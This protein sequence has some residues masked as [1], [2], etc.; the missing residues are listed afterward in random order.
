MMNAGN[1]NKWLKVTLKGTQSNKNG[2]GA[3]VEIYGV[4]GKQIRDVQSGTGFG[5]M[6]T[7]NVHFGIGQA[8]AITKVIVRWPSGLVDTIYNVN[9]NTTLNVVEGSF[10]GTKELQTAEEMF[11]VYP[12]PAHD[13]I[14]F[15]THSDFIPEQAKIYDMSGRN[16][17]YVKVERNQISVKDLKPGTYLLQITDKKGKSYSQKIAI[18]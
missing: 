1:T 3:R 17:L 6:S 11:K 14:Q 12:N 7:L 9:P 18:K 10:L 15:K 4:W 16:V 13:I 2:I 5:N 8:T